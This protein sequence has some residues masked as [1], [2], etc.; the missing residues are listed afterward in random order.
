MST[1]NLIGKYR[2]EIKDKQGQIVDVRESY[3]VITSKG[4]ER[5]I[6][7]WS[8]NYYDTTNSHKH[9]YGV[10]EV[11]LRPTV[12]GNGSTRR[13]TFFD[14]GTLL[15]PYDNSGGR[16]LN[17]YDSFLNDSGEAVADSIFDKDSEQVAEF[18]GGPGG[19]IGWRLE[20][21]G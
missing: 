18:A 7:I 3:N 8:Q 12:L 15:D 21:V 19:N 14:V 11:D 13:T 2:V 1:I 10:E 17:S 5:I 16:N 4:R 20:Y 9:M 6:D